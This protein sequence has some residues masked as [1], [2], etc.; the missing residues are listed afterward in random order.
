MRYLICLIGGVLLGA[1][2]ALT[3]ANA[4]QRRN[5]WPRAVMNVMQHELGSARDAAR[6]GQ[7]AT[8]AANAS[9]AHLALLGQ[10][11]EPALLAAGASDRV[12]TQ[13][14]D[15]LRKAVAKAQSAPDCPQR[16]AALTDVSN[17]CDA[18]HRDYR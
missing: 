9:T 5:A 18:C 11:L 2:I 4:L 3:A 6:L 14:A 10:D 15:D 8:P 12:F 7:C 16:S 1:L 17:A 13:Y